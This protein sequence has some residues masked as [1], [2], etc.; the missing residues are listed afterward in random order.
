M[1]QYSVTEENAPDGQVRVGGSDGGAR[2]SNRNS[3][4]QRPVP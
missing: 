1:K 4:S 2:P 3:Q